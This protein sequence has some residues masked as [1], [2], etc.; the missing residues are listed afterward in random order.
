MTVSLSRNLFS[1]SKNREIKENHDTHFFNCESTCDLTDVQ[2]SMYD[3]KTAGRPFDTIDDTLRSR[4]L[5]RSL[6]KGRNAPSGRQHIYN[7]RESTV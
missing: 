3:R 4:S 1:K 7:C 2:A 5:V 6:L